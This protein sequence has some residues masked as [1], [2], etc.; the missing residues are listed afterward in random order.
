[1]K[2][3]AYDSKTIEYKNLCQVITALALP[4][5]CTGTVCVK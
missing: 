1:M 2:K 4:R 3:K 5:I